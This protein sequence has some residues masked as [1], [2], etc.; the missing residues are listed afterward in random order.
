MKKKLIILIVLSFVLFEGCWVLRMGV[1]SIP[2]VLFNSPD[3]VT[4]KIKDP[5]KPDVRLSALW[6]GHSTVLLQIYDKVIIFDPVFN[7]VI[8]GL[9]M[10]RKEA[11]LDIKSIPNLDMVLVSHAHMDHMSLI[12]LSDLDD[13]FPKA[14]LIFPSGDEEYLP[15]YDMDMIRMKTGNSFKR[16]YVGETK[17]FDSV[18]VTAVFA[19]HF[20]GR[21]GLDSYLWNTPGCTGYIVEYRDVCIFYAGDTAYDD[22]AYKEI[23]RKYKIDLALIPIGPCRDCY[24]IKQFTHV[25]SYG[26]L[27]MLDDLNAGYMIPVH[28]GILTYGND[29]YQPEKVLRELLDGKGGGSN[30]ELHRFSNLKK[31]VKILTEGEQVVFDN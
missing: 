3:S 21:Y 25:T 30:D 27:L 11:G 29:P 4:N 24:T 1:R 14:K 26:A 10:R 17:V 8:G 19:E 9:V 16:G 6:V 23:G 2:D 28:Y 31:Q 22:E 7:D 20:G 13:K 5:I 15:D 12:S 18:K